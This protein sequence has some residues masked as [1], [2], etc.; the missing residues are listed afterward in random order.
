[1]T[2]VV[3]EYSGFGDDG[4]KSDITALNGSTILNLTPVQRSQIEDDIWAIITSR[5]TGSNSTTAAQEPS[6][7]MP[8]SL[9]ANSPT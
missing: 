1:M 6:P 4:C 9:G 2:Q 8:R 3:A 7:S 5:L